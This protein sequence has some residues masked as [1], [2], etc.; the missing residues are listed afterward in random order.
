MMAFTAC[1]A[2]MDHLLVFA[3][4]FVLGVVI[5]LI[6]VLILLWPW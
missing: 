4:R 1:G 2:T 6:F 5:P 3:V